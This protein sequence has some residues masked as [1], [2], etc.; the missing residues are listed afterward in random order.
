MIP[1]SSDARPSFTRTAIGAETAPSARVASPS[2]RTARV[3]SR[4]A[5]PSVRREMVTRLRP[6]ARTRNDTG[7]PRGTSVGSCSKPSDGKSVPRQ[8]RTGCT[9]A[10]KPSG[11][12]RADHESAATVMAAATPAKVTARPRRCA[13]C[14][15]SAPGANRRATSCEARAPSAPV[16]AT[17]NAPR[18]DPERNACS[19]SMAAAS[20]VSESTSA[21]RLCSSHTSPAAAAT[22][23]TH[24]AIGTAR[25]SVIH[26]PSAIS[27]ALATRAS[28][29]TPIT[30]N[31]TAAKERARSADCSRPSRA[32]SVSDDSAV[33]RSAGAVMA[34]PDS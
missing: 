19:R 26:R 34:S 18:S 4:Q 14:G 3:V 17:S 21:L 27:H 25:G 6:S 11:A 16:A 20:D 5:S 9:V 33:V 31:T 29:I 15:A 12:T 24:M 23:P 32:S 8:A 13:T 30:A 7:M 22:A 10:A 1:F 28:A 2:A